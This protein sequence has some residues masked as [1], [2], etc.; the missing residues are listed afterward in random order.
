MFFFVG[1]TTIY[2]M[3]SSH[4]EQLMIEIENLSLCEGGVGGPAVDRGVPVDLRGGSL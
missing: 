3:V 1:E 2:H 4:A